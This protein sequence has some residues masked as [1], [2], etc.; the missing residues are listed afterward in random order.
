M[1]RQAELADYRRMNE[2]KK[3]LAKVA[4]EIKEAQAS[5]AKQKRRIKIKRSYKADTSK[6]DAALKSTL[7]EI[8]V[9]KAE[10]K[11][12]AAQLRNSEAADK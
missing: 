3:R 9:L 1:E 6:N 10:Q 7:D 5:A 2:L 8:A 12:L 4:A 11:S